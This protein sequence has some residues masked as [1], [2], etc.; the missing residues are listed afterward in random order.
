[1]IQAL[2]LKQTVE[3]G[4]VTYENTFREKKNKGRQN[5]NVF[6]E[7]YTPSVPARPALPASP[8]TSSTAS[9]SAIPEMRDH[10][11]LSPL[12]LSLLNAKM[13]QMQTIVMNHFPLMNS[14]SYHAI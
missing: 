10:P 4:L 1:M 6:L 8:S 7:D 9:S 13:K 12:L 14:K 11:H 5:D 3:E 2:K